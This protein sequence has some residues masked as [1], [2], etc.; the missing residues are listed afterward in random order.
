[1][2]RYTTPTYVVGINGADLSNCR[3]FLTFRQGD[4]EVTEDVTG[5]KRELETD[6]WAVSVTLTQLQSAGFKVDGGP[7]RVQANAIDPNGY[8][9]PTKQKPL[10][11]GSNLLE[12]ILSYD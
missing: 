1:M 9:V 4:A 10:K 11:R 3:V 6:R 8:R 2:Y 5:T 12:R 7:L